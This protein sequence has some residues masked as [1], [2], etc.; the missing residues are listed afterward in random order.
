MW[1]SIWTGGDAV[2]ERP[3]C[4]LVHYLLGIDVLCLI[5]AQ[6]LAVFLLGVR[7]PV[8]L[9]WMI[10]TVVLIVAHAAFALLFAWIDGEEIRTEAGSDTEYTISEG[11]QSDGSSSG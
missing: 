4:L 8:S 5:T 11:S 10:A 9:P 6:G 2:T 1:V 3:L 7:E